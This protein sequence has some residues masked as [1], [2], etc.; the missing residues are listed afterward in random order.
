MPTHPGGLVFG[1][2]GLLTMLL[3]LG[4]VERVRAL[5]APALG[6]TLSAAVLVVFAANTGLAPGSLS[7]ELSNVYWMSCGIFPTGHWGGTY[8]TG[9]VHT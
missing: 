6:L 4:V 5:K 9:P 7:C 1:L 2:L 8:G 3:Y